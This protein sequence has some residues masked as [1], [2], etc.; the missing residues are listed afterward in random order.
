MKPHIF[1]IFGPGGAGKGTLERALLER[2]PDLWLSRSWTTRKQRPGEADDAYTFVDR[3]EFEQRA[4]EGGF[5]EWVEII[6]GQLSGTPTPE[7]PPGHDVLIEVD[8]RGAKM[9]RD[10]YPDA[11]VIM[12]LAPSVDDSEA[13]MR[14]RGDSEELIRTRREMAAKEEAEGRQIA[15]HVVVN[16]DLER[17]VEQLAG[18]VDARRSQEN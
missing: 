13:R 5:V 9:L 10:R 2:V 1:V 6:P 14:R 7:P 11:V 15:D 4:R 12:V 17:A 18:I 16:D 8:V 3:E